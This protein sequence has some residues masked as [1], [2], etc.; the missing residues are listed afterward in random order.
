MGA[1]PIS[2]LPILQLLP[3]VNACQRQR[4]TILALLIPALLVFHTTIDE[5]MRLSSEIGACQL[6][7][8]EKTDETIYFFEDRLPER[9][10][11]FRVPAESVQHDRDGLS[12]YCRLSPYGCISMGW[13]R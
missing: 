9:S 1:I 12:P 8:S 2:P 13:F 4:M 10:G 11:E 7:E 3:G 6:L 5:M